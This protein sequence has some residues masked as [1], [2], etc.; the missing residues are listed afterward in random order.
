ML[1][2]VV[3]RISQIAGRVVIKSLDLPVFWSASDNSSDV[4]SA[5]TVSEVTDVILDVIE[6]ENIQ[7]AL[8]KVVDNTMTAQHPASP[9]NI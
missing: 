3:L 1:S 4:G 7:L 2:N 5:P 8:L 9:A 6:A